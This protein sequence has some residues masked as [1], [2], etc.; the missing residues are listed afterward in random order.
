MNEEKL[1]EKIRKLLA[2]AES[3]NEYEAQLAAE[4]AQALLAEHNLSMSQISDRRSE[5]EFE[6]DGELMTLSRPWRRRMAGAVARMY[7]CK[8]FYEFVYQDAPNRSCGYIRYDK[9]CF[10]GARHNVE[11]AK[12]MFEY[13]ESAV[14]RMAS[15]GARTVPSRERSRYVTSFR[16]GAVGRVTAR[17]YER[18]EEAK[19]GGMIK[20]ESGTTLPALASLYDRT[21]RELEKWVNIHLGEL[22]RSRSTT[23]GTHGEGYRDGKAAGDKIGLD[24]QVQGGKMPGHLLTKQ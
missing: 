12:I 13:L 9:H 6:M 2:L 5:D 8:Y 21:Q 20:T 15:E 14:E 11:I 4:K 1:I 23:P 22:S 19:R 24:A 10:V 3:P 18:I 7:F 17:I 16:Y